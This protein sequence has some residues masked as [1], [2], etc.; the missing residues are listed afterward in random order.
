MLDR[1][2]AIELIEAGNNPPPSGGVSNIHLYVNAPPRRHLAFG[3]HT[4]SGSFHKSNHILCKICAK[5]VRS[6]SGFTLGRRC[7]SANYLWSPP[8]RSTCLARLVVTE[9]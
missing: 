2:I 1:L 3:I 6:L 8:Y 7:A 4:W 9:R 5:F